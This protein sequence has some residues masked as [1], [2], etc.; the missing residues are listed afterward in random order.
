MI[1]T[2]SNKNRIGVCCLLLGDNSSHFKTLQLKRTQADTNPKQK[3]FDVYKHNLHEFIRVLDYLSSNSISHYRISSDMFPL[4]DH[5]EFSELWDEFCSKQYYWEPAKNAAIKYL[6]SGGRLSTH[7]DQFCV[8]SSAR[9][10][11]NDKG[12]KNLEYH[13]KMFDMLGIPQSYFCPINIHVSN[14]KLGDDAGYTTNTNIQKLSSSVTSRLVFETEDKSYWTY[15]KLSKHFPDIPITLDYHHRLINNEGETEQEAHD[16]CIS[17]WKDVTPL[18]HY[19][20]GKASPL[21]RAH[22]DY[23]TKLPDCAIDVDIELEAKQK[24]LAVLQLMNVK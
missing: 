19:S 9:T 6:E 23:V 7:P 14:G 13:A 20:E 8:L 4:A 24:N 10:D 12:I 5:P 11:V 15:Q 22:S 17:T 16:A 18:F 21:D 2:T 1:P 3:V